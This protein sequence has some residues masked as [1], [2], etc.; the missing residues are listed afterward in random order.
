MN[1]FGKQEWRRKRETGRLHMNAPGK[2]PWELHPALTKERLSPIARIIWDARAGAADDAKWEL[3]ENRWDIGCRAFSRIK[4]AIAQAAVHDLREFLSI[5]DE[6]SYFVFKI[7]G[8][9]VRVYR[10]DTEEDAPT[11]YAVARTQERLDLQYAFALFDTPT[12]DAIFRIVVETDT[13]ANPTGIFLVQVKSDG[14]VINPWRIPLI[15]DAG[16]DG[17]SPLPNPDP[18]TPDVPKVGEELDEADAKKAVAEK[19]KT[20]GA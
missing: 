20:K 8:V 18:V 2:L 10:G 5:Q 14:T 19:T 9:P 3:G 15:A 7:G 1:G 16:E 11:R 6:S 4:R 17:G 13:K 12:P